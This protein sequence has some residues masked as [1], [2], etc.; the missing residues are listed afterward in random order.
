MTGSRKGRENMEVLCSQCS[1]PMLKARMSAKIGGE[2]I[3]APD[4]K[5]WRIPPDKLS[6]VR[7]YVCPSCGLIRMY[8]DTP[9]RL[10]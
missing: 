5:A 4:S 1:A 7:V 8:A 10:A 2:L 9:E 6:D 3:V